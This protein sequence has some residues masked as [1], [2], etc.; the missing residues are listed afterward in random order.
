MDPIIERFLESCGY[1]YFEAKRLIIRQGESADTLFYITQ[2]SVTVLLE[3][4]QGQDLVLAYLQAGDFFGELGL[5]NHAVRRSA[6]VYAYTPCEIA[7]I[8]YEKLRNLPLYPE[9]MPILASQ[10]ARRLRNT[11]RKVGDMAFASVSG[12]ILRTL[13]DLSQGPEART[14]PRGTQIR[15]TRKELGRIVGCSREVAGRVLKRLEREGLIS[16]RGRTVILLEEGSRHKP[17]VTR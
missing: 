13:L 10:V 2:G 7:C 3:L 9:L 4:H 5:F 17:S 11:N 6:S 8:D 12:R 1:R 15:I 14:H 16:T